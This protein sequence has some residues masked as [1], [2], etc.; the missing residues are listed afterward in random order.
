MYSAICSKGVRMCSHEDGTAGQARSL[1]TSRCVGTNETGSYAIRKNNIGLIGLYFERSD[2]LF[3]GCHSTMWT[4]PQCGAGL[5]SSPN[6]KFSPTILPHTNRHHWGK[7]HQGR[8]RHNWK[9]GSYHAPPY[10]RQA[11]RNNHRIRK[12]RHCQLNHIKP[13]LNAL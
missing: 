13:L 11:W 5:P 10:C 3:W 6:N 12:S 1:A 7:N 2:G 8:P 9:W 4:T